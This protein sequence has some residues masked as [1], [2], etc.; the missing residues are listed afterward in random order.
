[1]AVKFE[2]DSTKGGFFSES[3]MNF[4]D[5][6]ISRKIIPKN[7]PEL[8]IEISHQLQYIWNNFF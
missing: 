7:Y 6:Q 4:L 2:L 5:L 3:S 8:E 1:M